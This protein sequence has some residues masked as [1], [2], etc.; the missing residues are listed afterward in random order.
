MIAMTRPLSSVNESRLYVAFELG[1][2]TWKL[3]LTVSAAVKP[4]VRTVPS[5][6]VAK[7]AETVARARQRFGLAATDPV[8]CCYEAGRDGFW[9][10]RALTA[11]GYRVRVVDSS[12][13]EV[14]RRARRSKTDRLDAV[15]L[16]AMLLR[17]C[18]GEARVWHEVRVPTV[19]EETAR[20]LSRERAALVAETTR[21]MNQ[22][23]SLV[24][25]LGARLP[26]RRADAWWTQVRD[27]QG[28]P[29][30]PPVQQ[31][32][33]HAQARLTLLEAQIAAIEQQQRQ[34][35]GAD[36]GLTRL[37]QLKGIGVTSAAVLQDEGLVWR[38][39]RNRR[40]VGGMLGFRPVP[41]QS[42][43][44]ARDV[45][46]DRAGNKRWRAIMV[47]LAWGWVHWQP[48]SALAQWFERRFAQGGKRARRI[49]IVAVAR[50]LLVALWRWV[51][52]GVVPAGAILKAA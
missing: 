44:A 13:I 50:K 30:P 52:H 33:A 25:T 17:V 8:E 34:R 26:E 38:D 5:G 23:R 20:H 41:F 42:G 29:L 16:V 28:A 36:P 35:A 37:V 14:N 45:G 40:Q 6:D 46:I 19:A 31:R 49:G 18:G 1:A 21:V 10:Q 12:S 7:V 2:Q 11:V 9:L 4:W 47:Q 39:F 15:K 24:A 43:E 22:L 32:L 27:W 48:S 51:T 3:A